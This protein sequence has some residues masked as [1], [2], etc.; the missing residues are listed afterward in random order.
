MRRLGTALLLSLAPSAALARS[1]LPQMDFS[2]P[3]TGTQVIWMV[4][5]I[6]VL[7][8]VLAR[9]G[10]PSVG[11]VL[12][13]RATT[14][15]KNLAAA[16]AA[17]QEADQAVRVLA[18][19]LA[20]AR[21]NA[22]AEL[23]KAIETAKAAAAAEASKQNAALEAKI[24]DSEI[25]VEAARKA[26]IAAIKPVAIETTSDLLAKLTGITPGQNEIARYVDAAYAARKAA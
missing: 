3:L 19:T 20:S 13:N 1:A 11:K 4:V 25:Q 2:N 21:A 14:I 9:W 18:A 10:L 6:V 15:A 8:L 7:Y 17:K 24:A 5:I 22:K 23:S 26:A 16:R 12:E